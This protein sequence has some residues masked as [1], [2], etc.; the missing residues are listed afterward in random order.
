M[1]KGECRK[2]KMRQQE[3]IALEE[4]PCRSDQQFQATLLAK[5]LT[6]NEIK[7]SRS[8]TVSLIPRPF[9]SAGLGLRLSH[10]ACLLLFGLD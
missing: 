8:V 2:W 9:Q 6:T 10:C 1:E 5:I 7:K 3:Q 4:A